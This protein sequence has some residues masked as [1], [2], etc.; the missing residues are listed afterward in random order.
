MR[1]QSTFEQLFR[2]VGDALADIRERAVEEPWFGKIVT[3]R[4][5]GPHWPEAMEAE[6]ARGLTGEVL[7][8]EPMT[9]NTQESAGHLE[10]GYV[11]NAEPVDRDSSQHWP[12]ATQS[13]TYN[14]QEHDHDVEQ[15]LDH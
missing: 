7:E 8:P 6:Q 4:G 2:G 1:N 10:H 13:L 12:Q 15:D 14:P 9:G 11:L 5:D 3:E